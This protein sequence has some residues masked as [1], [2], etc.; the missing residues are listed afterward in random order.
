[1]REM[2]IWWVGRF[3]SLNVLE[4]VCKIGETGVFCIG[5]RGLKRGIW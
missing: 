3:D 4:M 5:G 1:M 2:L